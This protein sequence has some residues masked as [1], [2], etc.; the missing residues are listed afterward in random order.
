M[1]SKTAIA[2]RSLLAISARSTIVDVDTENSPEAKAVRTLYDATRDA[3]LRAAPWGFAKTTAYLSLLKSAPG[4]PQNPTAATSWDPATM[5][6]P[7]YLYEYDYPSQCLMMRYIPGTANIDA[8]TA[9]L[10]FPYG[11]YV[12]SLGSVQ[13]AVKFEVRSGT[14]ALGNEAT[15]IVTNVSDAIGVYVRRVE[16]E[17]L[18]DPSFQ[19]AMVLA[20]AVRLSN[21][22]TGSS[23]MYKI[24]K[25]QAEQ[26]IITARA[27][28]GNEGLT[29]FD[30]V[31]DWIRARGP[32]SVPSDTVGYMLPW[33]NPFFLF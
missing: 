25:S 20:L 15:T 23:D 2:N 1:T 32:G 29:R 4:T 26:A 31:P 16:N 12:P 11:N 21:T 28:D 3:M 6:P 33:L 30:H 27:Q 17:N 14:D 13:S 5:P 19:E 7:P 24:V 10:I 9:P 22:I 8:G 18:W